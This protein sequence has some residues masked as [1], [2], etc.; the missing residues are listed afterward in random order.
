MAAPFSTLVRRRAVSLLRPLR[1]C[2]EMLLCHR[3]AFPSV[4]AEQRRCAV[5]RSR[6]EV[7]DAPP[8]IRMHLQ[9]V[10]STSL[11]FPVIPFKPTHT[12]R[13]HPRDVRLL[14]RRQAQNRGRRHAT[15][16]KR[17]SGRGPHQA[18]DGGGPLRLVP[19]RV[20]ARH[21]HH[22][23]QRRGQWIRPVLDPARRRAADSAQQQ[24][25]RARVGDRSRV[26]RDLPCRQPASTKRLHIRHC[27]FRRRFTLSRS[28]GGTVSGTYRC[29]LTRSN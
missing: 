13:P 24:G 3:N 16:R 26:H 8:P 6:R 20:S 28:N 4:A 14:G 23:S 11:F 27:H 9:Q 7:G 15:L 17:A 1:S 21:R 22:R 18:W 2:R 5:L 10:R 29:T 25:R 12:H 19:G